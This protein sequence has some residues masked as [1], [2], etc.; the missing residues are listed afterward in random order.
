[1]RGSLRTGFVLDDVVLEGLALV[2][3]G[4]IRYGWLP[5][6]GGPTVLYGLN[7]AGKTTVL[8]ALE[9]VLTGINQ[10]GD[11]SAYLLARVSAERLDEATTH[12]ARLVNPFSREGDA[13]IAEMLADQLWNDGFA[14]DS[15]DDLDE[16]D[17]ADLDSEGSLVEAAAQRRFL[18]EATGQSSPGWGVTQAALL[19]EGTRELRASMEA[20]WRHRLEG[21][22]YPLFPAP[23][24]G[25]AE[26]LPQILMGS[27]TRQAQLVMPAFFGEK[28]TAASVNAALRE[29]LGGPL[30]P[31]QMPLFGGKRAAL[32]PDVEPLTERGPAPELVELCDRLGALATDELRRLLRTRIALRPHI[33]SPRHW[34]AGK[35]VE[36]NAVTA[37]GRRLPLEALSRAELRW[38]IVA[39]TTAHRL[40]ANSLRTDPVF[41]P[42]LTQLDKTLVRIIDEPEA[43]LHRSA[44]E[45]MARALTSTPRDE[46]AV[47]ATHSPALLDASQAVF[48]VSPH[49]EEGNAIAAWDATDQ[50]NLESLGV[51]R[52]DLLGRYAVMLAVEGV[53]EKWILEELLGAEL[54][55]SRVIVQ[56]LYG[57]S[58]AAELVHADF[59]TRFTDWTVVVM[60]DNLRA[61]ELAK[62]WQRTCEMTQAGASRDEVRAM[63]LDRLR[64]DVESKFARQFMEQAAAAGRTDRFGAP[65]AMSRKDILHYLP[66]KSLSPRMPETWEEVRERMAAQPT[67]LDEKKWIA[68]TFDARLDE[69]TIRA[70]VHDMESGHIAGE[71]GAL[72]RHLGSVRS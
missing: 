55:A 54:E 51:R 1:M 14:F 29:L 44:E 23:D 69:D 67:R 4:P 5:L 68:A 31:A 66:P 72:L 8:R 71:F 22:L 33:A 11:G 45:Q 59:V 50:D 7:G 49:H 36:W 28:D 6:D 48:L 27:L 62:A 64:G 40:L 13:G 63:L 58:R 38:A 34:L 16:E 2:D 43:A 25:P 30:E 26:G 53:H 65:F 10:S 32:D 47:L 57:G 17:V 15:F 9:S 35:P 18:V 70:A 24:G 12:A 41:G 42:P 19:G 46:M 37:N 21:P 52:S 39:T 56:P 61:D 3:C 20:R 60:W